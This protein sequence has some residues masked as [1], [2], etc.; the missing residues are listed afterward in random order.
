MSADHYQPIDHPSVVPGGYSPGPVR[1]LLLGGDPAEVDFLKAHLGAACQ[2]WWADSWQPAGPPGQP[3]WDAV[4]LNG[5]EALPDTLLAVLRQAPGCPVLVL[6]PRLEQAAALAA[7]RAGAQDVLEMSPAGLHRLDLAV[8]SAIERSRPAHPFAGSAGDFAPVFQ[9]S[10][11]AQLIFRVDTLQVVDANPAFC[12]LIGLP[13]RELIGGEVT[14]I[15]LSVEGESDACLLPLLLEDGSQRDLEIHL[16]SS[17][18]EERT[19]LTQVEPLEMGGQRCKIVSAID[20]TARKQAEISLR[21]SEEKFR[22]LFE[23]LENL[24]FGVDEDGRL[25]YLNDRAARILSSTVEEMTGR[26]LHDFLPA[27]MLPR[28]LKVIQGVIRDETPARYEISIPRQGLPHW[29]SVNIQP[30]RD[31][32]GRARHALVILTDIHELKASQH[33]LQELNQTLEERALQRSAEVQDLYDNAPIAYHSLDENGRFIRINRTELDWLGYRAEELLGEPFKTILAPHHH[34]MFKEEFNRLVREGRVSGLEYDLLCKD[35][36]LLPVTLNATAIYDPDRGFVASRSTMIDNREGRKAEQILRESEETYRALFESAND[37]I[38][39]IDPQGRYIRVNQ[40]CAE[41]LQYPVEELL[42]HAPFDFIAD[43]EMPEAADRLARLLRGERLPVYERRFRRKDG[44]VI[45]TEINLSLIRDHSQQPKLVQSVV[46]NITER[47]QAEETLRQANLELERA[48]RVKDEFLAAMS[49]EL[50]T[51]LTGI[52]GLSEVLLQGLYGPLNEK[53]ASS[54]RTIEESGRH[55]LQLINDILDLSKIESGRF[56]LRPVEVGV[57][58]ICQASFRLVG[59]MAAAKRQTLAFSCRPQ[60]ISLRADSRR[61]KQI[62]VNLLS[63]AI[64]FTPEGGELGLEV[65]ADRAESLVH[66]KVWDMGIGIAPEDLHRLFKPFVQLDS[67]LSRSYTGTGLGLSLVR[68]LA[69]LHGG[70]VS[71][72]SQPGAGSRFTLSLPWQ[73]GGDSPAGAAQGGWPAPGRR[74]RVLLVEDHD[75]NRRMYADFLDAQGYL[76]ETAGSGEE[77]LHKAALNPPG[78]VV[79][80]IQMPGMSGLE[81]IRSLRGLPD[82]ALSRVPI[83]ALTALAMPGDRDRCLEAGASAYLAKPVSL[84]DL[85]ASIHTLLHNPRPP[86][87]G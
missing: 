66:F 34:P 57:N 72:E 79:M 26:R 21:A 29:Y 59:P 10:P 67:S 65:W 35:G 9:S 70:R 74:D 2:V 85:A 76:V 41:L 31:G 87:G 46:R 27:R 1:L 19:L 75:A 8:R 20:I 50:R 6:A 15:G 58:E 12:Q 28:E 49:H 78:L 42:G 44:S 73:P 62:L 82:P 81:A 39:L 61:L 13:G 25:V 37:A 54:A 51:P 30:V 11:A 71:I 3:G 47:K 48:M 36:S 64:K 22:S 24:I 86:V 55:L 14:G 32:T 80:D 84:A 5:A 23:S 43:E 63:N 45:D 38:F 17:Q 53:Q 69:D 7:V 52:L 56:E 40:R 33:E 83:L 60:E 18:G 77:G 16:R 4:L 68:R